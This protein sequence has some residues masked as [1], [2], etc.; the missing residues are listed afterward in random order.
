VWF[1]LSLFINV[2]VVPLV[3]S[4]KVGLKRLYKSQTSLSPCGVV[5]FFLQEKT[6]TIKRS[7][8]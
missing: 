8:K 3:I 1:E 2:K 5:S 7:R 4:I 6:I